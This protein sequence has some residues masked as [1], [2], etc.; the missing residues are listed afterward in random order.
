MAQTTPPLCD[1]ANLLIRE[2]PGVVEQRPGV[3]CDA[4]SGPV[5]F[6]RMLQK[7][8]SDVGDVTTMPMRFISRTT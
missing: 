4:T 5:V 2:V 3:E 8:A 6:C 7:V 1:G